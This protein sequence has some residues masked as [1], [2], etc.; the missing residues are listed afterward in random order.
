MQHIDLKTTVGLALAIAALLAPGRADAVEVIRA[1][2][3]NPT[4]YCQAALPVFEGNIRKRPL[5]IQ[6]E[7]TSAAFVTCSFTGQGLDLAGIS[8]RFGTVF[9]TGNAQPVVSCTA[10][11]G[12][13]DEANEFVV[14]SA[15]FSIVDQENKTLSW[16]GNDFAGQPDAMPGEGL[17]SV[18]CNLPPGTAILN[19]SVVFFEDVGQ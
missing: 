7:G 10:V 12:A 16:N 3:A 14:K 19:S 18:S 11:T 2:R 9:F 15:G 1:F 4:S 13:S 8:M 5:A 17:I 6:N